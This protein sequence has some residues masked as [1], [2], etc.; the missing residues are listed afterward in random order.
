[1]AQTL[2]ITNGDVVIN[3]A[4]G[5]PNMVADGIKLRQDLAEFFTVNVQPS[6]FGAGI[7]QL[8]GVVEISPAIFVSATDRQ[9]REGMDIF[10]SLQQSETQIPR[11][12]E[13]KILTLSYLQ[14]EQ[15]PTNPTQYYFRANI[16]TEKGTELPLVVPITAGK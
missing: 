12:P 10:K 7:E 6:G 11:P 3:S 13:E 1:M 5:K 8:I 2:K 9:I 14:V 16:L 15:D 4:T